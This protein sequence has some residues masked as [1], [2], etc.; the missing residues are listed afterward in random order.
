MS[1]PVSSGPRQTSTGAGGYENP[2]G[3]AI[4]ADGEISSPRYAVSKVAITLLRSF[5]KVSRSLMIHSSA[6]TLFY[7]FT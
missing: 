2:A 6:S 5:G 7:A 1:R 4:T 3:V